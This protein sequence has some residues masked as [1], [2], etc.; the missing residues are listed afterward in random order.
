MTAAADTA[1]ALKPARQVRGRLFRKYVGLF[2]AVVCLALFANGLFEIW[3]SYQEHKAALIR[4]QREQAEAAAAKIGQF[5]KEIE[6]QLGWTVQLPWSAS[7]LEQRRFDA[8]RLLRQVPAITELSQLDSTG[9]EQLRVSRLAMD[10]VG[11]G[12]DFSKDP[13]FVETAARKVYYGPVYFRRESEPYMT[14]AVAGT[15]RDAGVSVAEVNLKLIWDVISQIKV[16]R[17]GHAYVVGPQGRL[18]A[19]PDISLVLRN[20]DMSGLPQVQAA[21]NAA[22]GD[23]LQEARDTQG[24]K[25]LT[26]HARVA[27]LR[28]FV[29]V[30][31]PVEEAYAPLYDSIRRSAFLLLG[32]LLLA[33]LAGTFLA[34][35][36]MVPIQALRAGAERIG[37]GELS[38]R[39]AVK[40][41]DELEAL[42][43]QFNDMAG[44]LEE[45]Y[46]GLERKVEERTRELT[47]ALET[48][49]ATGEILA[50]ISA[51][52]TDAK[53]VFEAIVR[54]LSRLFGTRFAVVQVLRDGMIEMP[55]VQG[56]PGFEKLIERYP[57]PLD[58]TTAGGRAMLSKRTLQYSPVL[59]DPAAPPSTQDFARDFG[60]N[61][62]IFT[63]MMRED[64]VIGAIGAA[65]HE[66][67]EFD[68]QQVALI[69]AFADQAVIAIENVRLF[70]EVQART[71]ELQEALEQQTATADILAAISS[72]QAQLKPV[73]ETIVDRT[74][75]LCEASFAC[76]AL[77]EGE[78]LRFAAIS[79]AS[80]DTEFFRPE[81]LHQ[82]DG[83]PYVLPLA[84]A[85]NTVQ[86]PDLRAEKGYLENDP[87]YVTA[88][89]VGGARTALRVPLLKDGAVLG[90]VWAFRQEVR[91][92]S[93][94]Q[95]ELI[96]NFAKQAVIAIEN[97][98]L[99]EA[100]QARTRELQE[101]LEYQ[102]AT[103]EVLGVISR[104]PN[105]LQPVF[106][107]IVDTAA[108]LCEAEHAFVFQRDGEVYRL[109]ANHG[110]SEEY[111]QFILD[112]PIPPGRATLVGRTALTAA[113]V[114]FP[115]CLADPEYKWVES[116]KRG[117]FRTMLG[118]PLLRDGAAVGVI[119]LTRTHVRPFSQKQIELVETF[120]D[121]AVIAIE[122]VRLFEE[123]Q[124]RT[125]EL[126]E[127]LE[128]QTA[129]SDVLNVISRSPS[130]IQPVLDTIVETAARL[131]DASDAIIALREGDWLKTAAHRGPIPV[132][133][134]AQL[135]R[136]PIGRGWVT[137]RAV[138]DRK[139]VHIPDLQAA[140]DE[141]PDGQT[142]A[143]RM[144]HRT[145][146][147]T[148]L[149]RED[150]AIGALVIR[151][152]EVRPF[153]EKQIALLQTFADQAVIAISNVRLFEEVQAR[154]RELQES[155]EY[156]TATS[157]VL[158]VMS[159]SPTDAKPVFD[160]I[161]TSAA[162][163]CGA[164][165]SNVQLFDGEMLHVA[166]THNFTPEVLE[167]FHKMYPRRPDRLQI[168]GRAIL[169]R[170]TVHVHDVLED[171]EYPRELALAGNWRAILSVPML[172]DGTAV[173][174]IT[175][176]K[177]EPVPFSGR[178]IELLNT[179][180]DQAVIAIGN[181][182]LFEEVQARTAELQESLEYQT[183]TSDVLN[184]ISRS[185]SDLQP[186]LDTIVE[187]AGRLCDAYDTTIFLRAGDRLDVAAH[188]GAISNVSHRPPIGRGW[189]TGRAV[190]DRKPVHVPDL[191]AAADEFP[192]AQ[193]MARRMGHRTILAM[194]L[195][196]DDVAIGAILLRRTEIR[197]FSDKQVAVL[198][199]FADQAVI[200]IE[201][202]RLFEE[203]Q[204]RTAE[205]TEALEQQTA[206]SEVLQAISRSTFDLDAVLETLVQ[207]AARL[208]EADIST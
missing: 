206:T 151:R 94:T 113:I 53:P 170:T 1:P 155:L 74:T 20:T 208:C 71:R 72:S 50:S 56:Q 2:V 79:G 31:L 167:Q 161:V 89:D 130:E 106:E 11:S 196:R 110:F 101:S 18:I 202:V 171:A 187:T 65:H 111:V 34:R 64:R 4:I 162:E 138:V 129:T 116:Q 133:F 199:T 84:H 140:A 126:Q 165:F 83:C 52:I 177:S 112:H 146:V 172:R 63:P 9:K 143:L 23:E 27:P 68:E 168:S 5:V 190:V 6:G 100:E 178:Q 105:E 169:S 91:P 144:G 137:G 109:A 132:A 173:G 166:A 57:R 147:A 77:F 35:R 158:N 118:V 25:V 175:V 104:A 80:A 13:K 115:D 30:E 28:W 86:T 192:D 40:T 16:G 189:V 136:F 121:Q 139:S 49:Q 149:M 181:V 36:M 179:F 122:N 176:S 134:G 78:A 114:H 102:T 120:A 45:S 194:P 204:A 159:R 141:F 125:A 203:V 107:A 153:S 82:P 145:I 75:R 200:A 127:S 67:R 85:R 37:R 21:S 51:S 108:R 7:T 17:Q 188:R 205:L 3:F 182:R 8:L 93:D 195:V 39:I 123:V 157:E 198:Q 32:A 58:E 15:R 186:V 87:F 184:V 131:C 90:H 73:F 197:P 69:R 98:R 156:Q 76:V 103:S 61:S 193:T 128:Y 164:V 22:E 142:M 96:G 41:G 150:A 152:T 38:Q 185:P 29:F 59:G 154:T 43:D 163:L 24:R 174:V 81:R 62:V 14:L 46:A 135:D 55:A 42:A 201:N 70:D 88:V 183:A 95:V 48:Q 60:F 99:F 19:H 180:A 54:N 26:A 66:T 10:V 33:A 119:A 12:T 47:K 92:F 124:A 97:A 44:R 160:A 148:P 191:L 117:G 207:S